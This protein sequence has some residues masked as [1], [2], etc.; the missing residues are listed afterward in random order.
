MSENT[1]RAWVL[2]RDGRPGVFTYDTKEAAERVA[3]KG[4]EV[5]EMVD[6][7]RLAAL[8]VEVEIWR[9]SA[10]ERSER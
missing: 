10:V 3:S 5:V 6:A 1:K 8:E 2:F 4:H 9:D 7:R